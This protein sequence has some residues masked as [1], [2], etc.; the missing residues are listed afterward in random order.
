LRNTAIHVVAGIIRDR[1]GRILL[2]QRPPGK[3]LAGLWEFP[4]GKRESGES[5]QDALRRELHEE[6]GIDAKPTRRLICFPWDYAE[7]SIFLDVYDIAEF[8]G[9]AHGREGQA[10]RWEYPDDLRKISMPAADVPIVSALRLPNRYAITPEPSADIERF[11]AKLENVLQAGIKLVQLRSKYMAPDALSILATQALALARR[12]G[13]RLMLNGNIDVAKRVLLDGIHL[14]S[15]QLMKCDRRPLDRPLLVGASCHDV[16]ELEHAV[17]IGAD[18]AVLGPVMPTNSHPNA[19]PLGW[20]K[21]SELCMNLPLPI[22]ALG[23]MASG[24]LPQALDTRAQGI[25]GISMFWNV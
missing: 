11:L 1:E 12:Y 25:A 4:G 18:F 24:D 5:P 2:T 17:G 9:I 19:Q 23:G 10:M 3:H 22:Y 14:S 21:F 20:S 8:S 13:A 15:T 16:A 6:I 7:K